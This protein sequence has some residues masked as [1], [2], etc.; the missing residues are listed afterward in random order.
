[1]KKQK[2]VTI[3]KLEYEQLQAESALMW[4]M[5]NDYGEQRDDGTWEHPFFDAIKRM[6]PYSAQ[7]VMDADKAIQEAEEG[8]ARRG[9]KRSRKPRQRR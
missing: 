3:S 9:F 5:T 7:R 2:M 6:H 8:E 1:M 4:E